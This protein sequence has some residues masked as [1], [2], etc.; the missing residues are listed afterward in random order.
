MNT[1]KKVVISLSL[2]AVLFGVVACGKT[3]NVEGTLEEIMEKVYTDVPEDKRPM[4]LMNTEVTKENVAYYLGTDDIEF[5]EALASESGTGSIAHSI[6]LVRTKD[7]AD[8]EKIKTTIKDNVDPRKWICVE[9]E[10]VEVKSKGNLII[11]IMSSEDTAKKIE[12]SFDN[13]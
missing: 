4:M 6:V 11:L 1:V 2:F 10:S 8:V 5:E 12:N 3:K 9:A 7:G 13:L